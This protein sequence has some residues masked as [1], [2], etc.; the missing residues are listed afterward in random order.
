MITRRTTGAGVATV[1]ALA[2]CGIA[3]PAAAAAPSDPAAP[4][5]TASASPAPDA[6]PT[7][8]PGDDENPGDAPDPQAAPDAAAEETPDAETAPADTDA[9]D[10]VPAD[11]SAPPAGGDA[12]SPEPEALAADL[13]AA[14]PAVHAVVP[15][16][17]GGTIVFATAAELAA[18]TRAVIESEGLALS[19]IGAPL[20]AEAAGDVVGGAGYALELAGGSLA[21]SIGFSAWTPEGGDAVIT[22]GH[23]AGGVAGQDAWLTRP[24]QDGGATYERW[25]PLGTVAFAQFGLPGDPAGRT[26]ALDSIDIAAVDVDPAAGLTPRPAVT[27]WTTAAADDLA[28][29]ATPIARIGQAHDGLAVAKSGRTTGVTT[30]TVQG[31][32]GWARVGS[33]IVH[34]FMTT[35][36][37]GDGDS[38]GAVYADDAAL[39]VVSG[40]NT[41]YTWVADLGNALE[42]T[43]GYTLR[44]DLAEPAVSAPADL[45]AVPAGSALTGTAHAGATLRIEFAAA[46]TD[47]GGSAPAAQEV[48]VGA[49]GAW[50][51]TAPSEPGS[52]TLRLTSRDGYNASD[53][54]QVRIAVYAAAEV[55]AL[56]DCTPGEDCLATTGAAVTGP[57]AAAGALFALAVPLLWASRRRAAR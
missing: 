57:L 47:A 5:A 21:C 39:G 33:S 42:Q 6:A 4:S 15:D 11:P 25:L 10:P 36:P 28:A 18:H 56:D 38:G 49:D 8:A 34:G 40:G 53:P 13:L 54:T 22:A 48:P 26:G 35:L 52:Y 3:V 32:I 9:A 24:S 30:G 37:A 12:A 16:G 17:A 43:G 45:G 44:L 41:E 7:P 2:L 14:D 27:D 50:S 31:G 19:D 46:E 51:W 20:R 1:L 23:C 29:S 55:A